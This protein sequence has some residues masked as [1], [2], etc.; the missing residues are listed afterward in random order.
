MKTAKENFKPT[1]EPEVLIEADDVLIAIGQE[2]TFPGLKETS[3][4][5]LINGECQLSIPIILHPL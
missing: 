3:A 4:W 1:G 2:N 5:S